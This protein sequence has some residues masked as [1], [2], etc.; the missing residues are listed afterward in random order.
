[1]HLPDEKSG[2]DHHILVGVGLARNLWLRG[3]PGQ[4]RER[5][6]QTVADAGHKNHPASL[7]LALSW[8]P[9]MLLWLGDLT[10]AEEHADWLLSHAERH[11]LGPYLGVGRGYKGALAIA[12]GDAAFGVETLRVCLDHLHQVRYEMLNTGFKLALVQ[13]L[14]AIGAFD[15]G[16][17]L[18][19]DVTRLVTTNGDLLHMPEALRV[20]G[21]ALLSLPQRPAGDAQMC[22]TRSL[23]W[24]RC[25]GARSWELRTAVDLASLWAAQGQQHRARAILRPI[26]EQ[27]VE[28]SDTPDLEAAENLLATL[29]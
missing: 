10:S 22:F 24:S 19:D 13:G 27:F 23:D 5:I 16:L 1:M 18:I 11:S 25:Q 15:E 4:A 8:A 9:G 17:A 6:L 20:K 7:G 2:L 26:F 3:Y 12:R 28:G 14:I 29:L 21:N